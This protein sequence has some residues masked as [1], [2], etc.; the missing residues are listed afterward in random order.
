M[1]DLWSYS[2]TVFMA[3]FA[4]M[5]PI[6]NIPVFLQIYFETID[7]VINRISGYSKRQFAKRT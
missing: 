1:E 5:N 4:I 3:F 6:V 2:L 7:I